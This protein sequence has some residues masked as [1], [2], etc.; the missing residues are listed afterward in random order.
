[1]NK[2]FTRTL[3]ALCVVLVSANGRAIVSVIGPVLEEITH[4]LSMTSTV[5]GILTAL[6]GFCF[7]IFGAM[8]PALSKKVGLHRT[9]TI[10]MLVL[11]LASLG[12]TFT[13]NQWVFVIL[14]LI[15]LA[16]IATTNVLIP[17]F[18][19]HHFPNRIHTM[20]ITYTL[21]MMGT[22]AVAS[23]IAAPIATHI[24]GGWRGSIG[25]WSLLAFIAFVLMATLLVT[26]KSTPTPHKK[27]R[28][29]AHPSPRLFTN[30]KALALSFFF[31]IQAM[32][33]FIQ[34]GW[35]AQMFRDFG[36]SA[37]HAG[38]L[39]AILQL[40]SVLGA[41]IAPMLLKRMRHPEYLALTLALLLLPGYGGV[42]FAPLH[43]TL[44]WIVL[45]AVSGFCFPIALSI[46]SQGSNT[47]QGT[48]ELSGFAQGIGFIIAGLGPFAIG[49]MHSLTG[50]WTLPLSFLMCLTP[51]FAFCAWYATRPGLI[52][53]VS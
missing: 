47:S 46:I 7:G 25:L 33:A 23:L 6:P 30:P 52:H 12:R 44:L 15:A 1:M 18:I 31:G 36:L 35:L 39:L 42:L 32:Q 38:A 13:S 34:F 24:P 28:L 16:G 53:K 10:S 37:N 29:E 21:S 41:F 17:A 43:G 22:A 14:T 9:L 27:Q 19:Y 49:A 3:L 26:Y 48:A 45:L 51:I 11:F 20:T 2:K 4:D 8:T 50:T 40:I 5:A